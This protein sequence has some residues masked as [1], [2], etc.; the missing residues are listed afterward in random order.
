MNKQEIKDWLVDHDVTNYTINDDLVVDVDN[1]VWLNNK[2]QTAEL[3][4][5]F[6]KVTGFFYCAFSCLITL[7]NCPTYVGKSFT[8]YDNELTSLQYC[9][10]YV[11]GNF[12]CYDNKLTSLQ[13]CPR[14]VGGDFDCTRNKI[15]S[16]KEL[17]EIQILGRAIIVDR[18]L[19][20]T[21][22]YKLLMK[23]RNI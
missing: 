2:K 15:S 13:H 11:G 1:D 10:R 20:R 7:H 9:P 3:P 5:K 14:Y 4:V 21:P 16:I 23:L 6:G 12:L 8:C 17:L 18:Q 22:E 19:E